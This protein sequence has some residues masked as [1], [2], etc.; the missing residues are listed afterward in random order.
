MFLKIHW[1]FTSNA[2]VQSESGV[3]QLRKM[4]LLQLVFQNNKVSVS[5]M[6]SVKIE[7]D[8]HENDIFLYCHWISSNPIPH[9]FGDNLYSRASRNQ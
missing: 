8:N 2:S 3:Q 7:T 1:K 6:S 5:D 9:Y 4:M